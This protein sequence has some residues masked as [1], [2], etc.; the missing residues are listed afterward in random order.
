[1]IVVP[2]Q[3]TW[4][5]QFTIRYFFPLV[6]EGEEDSVDEEDDE[7]TVVVESSSFT[8]SFDVM[9]F[10]NRLFSFSIFLASCAFV[11]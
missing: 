8:T 5:H 3:K 7:A 11:S 9:Y 1:V 6:E 10:I 2:S 4:H